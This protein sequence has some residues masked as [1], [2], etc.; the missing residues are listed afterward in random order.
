A[1]ELDLRYERIYAYL[2]DD[3]TKKRPSVD[4]ILS[5]LSS[6]PHAKLDGRGKFAGDAP[7]IRHRLVELFEDPAQVHPPLLSQYLKID[8]RIASYLLGSDSADE[9]I[10]PYLGRARDDARLEEVSLEVDLRSRL[11]RFIDAQNLDA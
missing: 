4:L 7:L 6:S 5:L 9:R 3:I 2:Q 11:R 10:R 1:P 8:D